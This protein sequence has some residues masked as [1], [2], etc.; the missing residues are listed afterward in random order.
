MS[1]Q[2]RLVI[3]NTLN[4]SK[5]HQLSYMDFLQ[6]CSIAQVQAQKRQFS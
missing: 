2:L 1:A 6:S 5:A 4:E 3:E